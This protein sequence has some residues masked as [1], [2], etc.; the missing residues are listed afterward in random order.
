MQIFAT[1]SSDGSMM[2]E[3][4]SFAMQGLNLLGSLFLFVIGSLIVLA[5]ILFIIDVTQ[6]KDTRPRV[7]SIFPP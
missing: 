3:V 7:F 1:P 5:L 6:T 4:T 2:Q